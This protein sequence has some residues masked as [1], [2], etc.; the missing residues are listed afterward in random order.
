[1]AH[2]LPDRDNGMGHV[3]FDEL[4]HVEKAK[5]IVAENS[6]EIS[7]VCGDHNSLNGVLL[8]NGLRDY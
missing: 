6:R 7:A 3:G 5:V 1:M 8:H 4:V 2:N